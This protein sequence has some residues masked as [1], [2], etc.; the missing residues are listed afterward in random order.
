MSM[1]DLQVHTIVQL[2][3]T[4]NN[5]KQK[6]PDTRVYIVYIIPFI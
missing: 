4:K 3:F 2:H 1:N 6:K 5:A